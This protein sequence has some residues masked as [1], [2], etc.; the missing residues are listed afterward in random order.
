MSKNIE[1]KWK[2]LH[3]KMPMDAEPDPRLDSSIGNKPLQKL[4]AKHPVLDKM[5]FDDDGNLCGLKTVKTM[6]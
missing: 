3:K 5:F 4:A 2:E 6:R 1:P